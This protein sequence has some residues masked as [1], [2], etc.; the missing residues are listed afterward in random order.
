M[1]QF[2]SRSSLRQRM[3]WGA[4]LEHSYRGP[5]YEKTRETCL[6]NR[7]SLNTHTVSFTDLD[8]C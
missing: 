7:A 4:I 6:I 2:I 5:L 1:L 8:C 3:S